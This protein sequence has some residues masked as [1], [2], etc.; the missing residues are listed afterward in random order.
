VFSA[1]SSKYAFEQVIEETRQLI[2]YEFIDRCAE[3][4][5]GVGAELLTKEGMLVG[6]EFI[7]ESGLEGVLT[8]RISV[9]HD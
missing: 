6:L 9:E 8:I 1:R 7:H 4:G 5:H 3:F 2:L